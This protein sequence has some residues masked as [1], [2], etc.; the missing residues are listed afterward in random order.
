M[1]GL[2][3]FISPTPKLFRSGFGLQALGFALCPSK[4]V[5]LFCPG[6][7]YSAV[8]LWARLF[9]GRSCP[10]G[11]V[12]LFRWAQIFGSSELGSA[13]RDWLRLFVPVLDSPSLGSALQDFLK[14]KNP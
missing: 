10:L 14:G 4:G 6:L 11:L 12:W 7:G 5:Q 8:L 3:Y 9:R 13:L 1:D 2:H